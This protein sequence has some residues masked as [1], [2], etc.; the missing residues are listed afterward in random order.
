MWITGDGRFSTAVDSVLSRLTP[1]PSRGALPQCGRALGRERE[2]P[3]HEA[4][5]AYLVPHAELLEPA[6]GAERDPCGELHQLLVVVRNDFHL[7]I[8]LL[9]SRARAVNHGAGGRAGRDLISRSSPSARRPRRS[10]ARRSR[11]PTR[12]PG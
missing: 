9:R 2:G 11:S 6:S 8:T 4:L 3:A 1:A 7:S 10:R 5:H 12:W